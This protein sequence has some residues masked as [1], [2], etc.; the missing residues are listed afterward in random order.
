MTRRFFLLQRGIT[1]GWRRDG[2]GAVVVRRRRS[3]KLAGDVLLSGIAGGGPNI[4][5]V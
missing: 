5:G 3:R 4:S 1:V 2:I